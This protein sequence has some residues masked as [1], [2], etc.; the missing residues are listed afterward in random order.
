VTD[1][2]KQAQETG[3]RSTA[4]QAGRDINLGITVSEA[5]QIALDVFKANA[6][7]LAGIAR[8]LFEARGREF[9][10]RYLAE[11]QRRRPEALETF[12]DPDMQY[13]L[14]S[15]QRDFARSGKADL[16]QLLINLLTERTTATDLKRIVLNEAIA[17]ASQVTADQLDTLSLLLLFIHGAPMRYRFKALED[18]GPYLRRYVGPFVNVT[19]TD[20]T[21]FQHLKYAGCLSMDADGMGFLKRIELAFHGCFT[22][23]FEAEQAETEPEGAVADIIILCLH[24]VQAWQLQ[25][26]DDMTFRAICLERGMTIEGADRLLHIQGQRLLGSPRC[27]ETLARLDPRFEVLARTRLNG[28]IRFLNYAQLTSVGIALANANLRHKTGLEF[29]LEHWIK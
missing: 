15:A 2:L 4:M 14:F 24:N 25:P 28:E 1:S 11:L 7:E 8:D 13:V 27:A 26:M 18:L 23:G 10:E 9:I 5:R 17:T 12:R 20:P 29:P 19:A 6:L 22:Y 16:E 21:A 3:D